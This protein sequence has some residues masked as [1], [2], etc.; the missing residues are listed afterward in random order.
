VKNREAVTLVPN[1]PIL[2]VARCVESDHGLIF[3]WVQVEVVN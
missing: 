2:L 3:K 1:G